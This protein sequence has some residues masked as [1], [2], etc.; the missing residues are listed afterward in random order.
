MGQVSFTVNDHP[1]Q[2]ACEDGQ[3]ERLESLAKVIDQK[4]V[5]LVSTLGHLGQDRLLLMASILLLDEATEQLGA[6][7]VSVISESV[8]LDAAQRIEAVAARLETP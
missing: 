5:D 2:L 1:Y 6:E 4:V 7:N 8:L 3:E